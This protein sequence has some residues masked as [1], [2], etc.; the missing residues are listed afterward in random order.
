[1]II[2]CTGHAM[3]MGAFL[4]NAVDLRI[5][6][7]GEFKIA[8]NEVAIGMT[9][10]YTAIELMRPRLTPAALQR[11]ALLSE[12]FDPAGAVAVGYLDRIVALDEVVSAAHA[13]ATAAA[14]GLDAGA[15]K[16]TKRRLRAAALEAI[17]AA[18]VR[19][20]AELESLFRSG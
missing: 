3:A 18:I 7:V 10:P 11:S 19:D 8:A 13:A 2:A 5:G 14:T 16:L 9:V 12:V 15:H 17:D 1:M 6:A 20:R 4:L